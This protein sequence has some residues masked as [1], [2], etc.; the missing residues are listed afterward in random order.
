MVWLKPKF[1]PQ[2]SVKNATNQNQS[3]TSFPEVETTL[4][5]ECATH[6][7]DS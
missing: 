4:Q 7:F 6:V 2:E 1:T 5:E 3:K